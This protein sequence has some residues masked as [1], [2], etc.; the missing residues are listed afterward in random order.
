MQILNL[1]R[2]SCVTAKKIDIEIIIAP[3]IIEIGTVKFFM[4]SSY[5]GSLAITIRSH[6]AKK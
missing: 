6:P 3:T 2:L 1:T 4:D 5:P